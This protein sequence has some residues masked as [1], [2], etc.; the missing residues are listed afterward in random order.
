VRLYPF[1]SP[2]SA[3]ESRL[4]AIDPQVAFG[5]PVLRRTGI[6]TQAIAARLDAG[7]TVGDIASDYE[8]TEAEVEQA[9]LY[10]RAAFHREGLSANAS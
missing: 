10:E 7:E 5:R 8:L 1:L 9:V 2:D 4:I 3:S 6:S